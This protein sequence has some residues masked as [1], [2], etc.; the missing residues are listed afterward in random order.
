[1]S[2]SS[3]LSNDALNNEEIAHV[4][5]DRCIKLK[6]RRFVGFTLIVLIV[7]LSILIGFLS[8]GKHNNAIPTV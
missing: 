4:N 3:L 6:D 1:M 7:S 8:L 5:T 2:Q